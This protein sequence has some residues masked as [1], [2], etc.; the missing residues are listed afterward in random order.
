MAITT[1]AMMMAPRINDGLP[2]R[3]TDGSEIGFVGLNGSFLCGGVLV[4]KREEWELLR[5]S[6]SSLDA[7]LSHIGVPV[8][9]MESNI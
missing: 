5:Q 4:K 3:A 6:H 8:M 9:E 1:S 7:V 2:L